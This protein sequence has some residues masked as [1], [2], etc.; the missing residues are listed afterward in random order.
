MKKVVLLTMCV[1]CLGTTWAQKRVGHFSFIPR[2]GLNLSNLG[3]MDIY[4]TIDPKGEEKMKSKIR[5]DFMLGAD[6]EYQLMAPLGISVGAYYSR[7]GCRWADF[8]S[9]TIDN[10]KTKRTDS[11]Q[12]FALKFQ[13]INVPVSAKL[14]LNDFFA[15]H[16]GLQAGFAIN[17]N[18][19][20]VNSVLM[21]PKVGE[22][23]FTSES[24]DE[25]M[26][27]MNP[28]VLSIPL[29]VSME[30]DH[31]ILDARY[32]IPLSRFSNLKNPLDGSYIY[33][34]GNRVWTI[35]VGYRF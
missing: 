21:E 15:V 20:S 19:H 13:Y 5:P 9:V 11:T 2:V 14:Y 24:Y 18:M 22:T 30:Y 23:V 8:S 26:K 32:N 3:D 29:G 12:D 10:D 25:E 4:T 1:L 27:D 6:V 16:A 17:G 28:L 31:V 33:K 34:G 7:Q 35:S